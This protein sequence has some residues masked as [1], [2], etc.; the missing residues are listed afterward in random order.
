MILYLLAMQ[1]VPLA[2]VFRY[3]TRGTETEWRLILVW[4]LVLIL[5]FWLVWGG[6]STDGWKYLSRFDR[7]P[8]VFGSERLFW[9]TGHY[10]G[11]VI[12]DPWPLKILSAACAAILFLSYRLWN[13]PG[14]SGARLTVIALMILMW[15]PGNLL[16][17]GN[18]IRQGL[19]TAFLLLGFALFVRRSFIWTLVLWILAI[20]FHQM[21]AIVITALLL[22]SYFPRVILPLLFVAPVVSFLF[23]YL[24]FTQLYNLERYIPYV[25]ESAGNLHYVKFA[26]SYGAAF[27]LIYSRKWV[28]FAKFD[29]RLA[30]ISTVSFAAVFL[31]YEVPFERLL[32]Y[33]DIILPL[34]LAPLL[35][36][37]AISARLRAIFLILLAT[38]GTFLWSHDSISVTLGYW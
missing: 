3:V 18:V 2:A 29:M 16:L 28:S 1:A 33:S 22:S 32:L 4:Q 27:A 25:G 8:F 9:I 11:E 26:F 24:P 10:L 15:V 34:A 6:Y 23:R 5:V 12:E 17:T 19:S 38:G 35:G 14:S 30:Y 36:S 31:S 7:N 21:G 37:G 20:L 13:G